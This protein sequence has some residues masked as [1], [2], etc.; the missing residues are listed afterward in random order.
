MNGLNNSVRLR[1]RVF[2]FHA[3]SPAQGETR[4]EYKSVLPVSPRW[5]LDS[6]A[7]AS[8]G[9]GQ[10]TVGRLFLEEIRSLHSG[11]QK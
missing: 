2:G 8:F 11:G 4:F 9:G 1:A 3:W 10:R 5:P 7:A 6:V